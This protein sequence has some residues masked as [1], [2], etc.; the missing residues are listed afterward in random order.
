MPEEQFSDD[1]ETIRIA[2]E[3]SGSR[4]MVEDLAE[5]MRKKQGRGKQG[6]FEDYYVKTVDEIPGGVRKIVEAL[7]EYAKK[8]WQKKMYYSAH[9]HKWFPFD[10]EDKDQERGEIERIVH[11]TE[12]L[13]AN[14]PEDVSTFNESVKFVYNN[15]IMGGIEG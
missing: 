6:K 7:C 4:K 14:P 11:Q 1:D 5:Q 12:R 8:V 15:M 2:S 9:E 13:L 10:K 3:K